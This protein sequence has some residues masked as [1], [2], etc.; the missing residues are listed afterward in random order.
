MNQKGFINIIIGIVIAIVIIGGA[1]GYY[2]MSKNRNEPESSTQ[3]QKQTETTP[4]PQPEKQPAAPEKT[5]KQTPVTTPSL[6]NT[7]EY[8]YYDTNIPFSFRYPKDYC[9]T[10][11]IAAVVIHKP[12]FCGGNNAV[13]V[14]DKATLMIFAF[15][16]ENITTTEEYVTTER[17]RSLQKTNEKKIIGGYTAVKL[18]DTEHL[19]RIMYA[20]LTN[21]EF[22]FPENEPK[23][24]DTPQSLRYGVVIQSTLSAESGGKEAE[25]LILSTFTFR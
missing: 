22:K 18:I 10:Q 21:Y 6:Q 4:N 14:I 15:P 11:D 19:D 8:K 16:E 23:P 9:W 13:N 24:I 25:E 12:P 17:L 3:A 1:T 20:F 5:P 2:Y 7:L